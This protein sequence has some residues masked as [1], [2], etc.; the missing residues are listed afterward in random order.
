MRPT[1]E[2]IAI[3]ARRKMRTEARWRRCLAWTVLLVVAASVASATPKKKKKRPIEPQALI[4]GTVF[5]KSGQLLPGATVTVA[6][7]ADGKKRGQGFTDRRGEFAIRVPAGRARYLV[8]AS[9]KGF[10]P[11]QKPVD[12]YESEKMVVTFRLSPK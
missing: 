8:T 7:E 1:M 5:Q 6:G 12:I 2:N 10:E 11:Q 4:A 3:S 9:A